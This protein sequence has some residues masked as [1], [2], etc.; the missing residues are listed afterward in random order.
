[1][2]QGLF[3]NSDAT[4][5]QPEDSAT[6]A[7]TSMALATGQW[8]NEICDNGNFIICQRKI[9]GGLTQYSTVVKQK[10]Q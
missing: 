8:M 5:F 9:S 7:C 10:E 4:A 6:K 1:M 3:E 2:G